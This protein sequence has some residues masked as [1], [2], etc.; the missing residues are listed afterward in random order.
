M[1]IRLVQSL[2]RFGGRFAESPVVAVTP[3]FGPPLGSATC[4]FFERSGVKHITSKGN[5]RYNWYHFLNKPLALV[6]AEPHVTTSTVVWLDAD[7]MVLGEPFAWVLPPDTD[8]A[9]CAPDIDI[10][11]S[12]GA[13]DPCEP[14]W[15]EVSSIL[16]VDLDRLPFMTTQVDKRVI[17]LYWQGG[18][19]VYRAST[20]L[21]RE[22]LRDCIKLL[23]A[24]L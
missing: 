7:T 21:A 22:Y 11:G 3:R 10:L 19:F 18:V 15:R 20:G 16:G 17:R 23:D 24:F 6:A 13:D 8:F 9:A 2:R 14:C 5:S 1:C 4:R 12:S